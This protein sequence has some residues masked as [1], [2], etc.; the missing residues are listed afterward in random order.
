MRA[1]Y[2][3]L[4]FSLPV[5]AEESK[6]A[7]NAHQELVDNGWRICCG[8]T[9]VPGTE[10]NPAQSFN[11]IWYCGKIGGET[12]RVI[13][14]EK[15]TSTHFRPLRIA[16]DGTVTAEIWPNKLIILGTKDEAAKPGDGFAL[17]MPNQKKNES[18]VV[19]HANATGL[20]VHPYL[21]N[22]K[23]TV[24]WVPMVDG[25]PE[26]AKAVELDS[27]LANDLQKSRTG[28]FVNDDWIVWQNRAFDVATGQIRKLVPESGKFE[29]VGID[30]DRAIFRRA[31]VVDKRGVLEYVPLE[32]KT[33]VPTGRY[34]STLT[35]QFLL[36]RNR[37]AYILEPVANREEGDIVVFD[38][39]EPK[40]PLRRQTVAFQAGTAVSLTQTAKGF[41]LQG[42]AQSTAEWVEGKK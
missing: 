25:K 33:G 15:T 26:T 28:F 40:E 39:A 18:T 10:R 37:V 23:V 3:C 4:L 1:L 27:V 6:L 12:G 13:F 36:A 14:L 19:L 34:V 8:M 31:H 42:N 11:Y 20:V 2:F 5:A 35:S 30:G 41:Y 29:C 24:S 32:L 22:Q 16:P 21:L 7:E 9:I 17:V 38:L